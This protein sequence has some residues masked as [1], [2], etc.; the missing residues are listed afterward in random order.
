VQRTTFFSTQTFPNGNGKRQRSSFERRPINLAFRRLYRTDSCRHLYNTSNSEDPVNQ[1]YTLLLN[2]CYNH[3]FHEYHFNC[4]S[5]RLFL[6]TITLRFLFF[7]CICFLLFDGEGLL[8]I[9]DNSCFCECTLCRNP[10]FVGG[11]II[12]DN[13]SA[14]SQLAIR[15]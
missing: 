1:A 14:R 9:Y 3:R 6:R 10:P 13:T 4:P 8:K 7:F 2:A 15:K 11:A 5:S 12:W